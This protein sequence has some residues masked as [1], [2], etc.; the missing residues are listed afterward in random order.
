MQA[1]I[2]YQNIRGIYYSS[3][4][5][6]ILIICNGVYFVDDRRCGVD[7]VR[8]GVADSQS[9]WPSKLYVIDWSNWYMVFSIYQLKIFNL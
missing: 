2:Y 9:H 4:H 7:D 8:C 6:G 5:M 3:Y 1:Y